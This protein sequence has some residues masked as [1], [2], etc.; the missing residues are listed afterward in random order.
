METR[1]KAGI[2]VSKLILLVEMR[3]GS[4]SCK[5]HEG[6]VFCLFCFLVAS[7]WS[8]AGAVRLSVN[9]H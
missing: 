1:E 3:N 4:G 7:S 2:P 5:F 8:S 6:R 9:I